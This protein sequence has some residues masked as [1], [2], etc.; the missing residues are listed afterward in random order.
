MDN[1]NE[2]INQMVNENPPEPGKKFNW[3]TFFLGV[4]A[5]AFLSTV[6][7]SVSFAL[8]KHESAPYTVTTTKVDN[9]DSKSAK[10]DDT[11][12]QD[13]DSKTDEYESVVNDETM[14]KLQ[15]LEQTID[16]YYIDSENVSTKTL[17]DGMYEGM[18]DSL[19]DVY[20]V[21]Y[22]EEELTALMEDTNG[23]Y[24]GIGAY[25]STDDTT[26]LPVIAGVM[27]G[28]PAQEAGLK[29]GD[30]CYK[31]DGKL[32]ESMTLEEFIRNVKGE[33]HTKVLLTIVREGESD[34]LEIEVERRQIQTPTVKYEMKEGNIGYI[35]IT[36]FDTVTSDQFTEALVTL[37]GQGMKGLVIDLRSNPGGNL[38]T[39]CEIASQLLPKGTIVYTVDKDGNRVDYN[40]DGKN[41]FDMPMVVLV[42]GYSASASEIL[43]GA[44]K[45]YEMGTLVGTTTYGK[46][47]V[48][49]I[50]PFSDGTAV[51]LTVSKYYTPNGINIHGTGIDPDVEIEYDP[52]AAEN[53][54]DN[55]LDK[56]LEI[57]A[58]EIG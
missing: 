8:V 50:I 13:E 52:E 55:Q 22:T 35:Q 30:V 12:E 38:D 41:E 57:I 51:K 3:G 16:E 58:E 26:G 6:V 1:E 10:E 28:S 53:G 44:I 27:D 21:Y 56:A 14:A 48:Q 2:M 46:G 5:G 45:D 39:V 36:E 4:V 54:V 40:C 49:R 37:K 42:N 15:L 7:F 17:T 18:L 24:Y 31:V 47:I 29:E 43:A 9:N 34:Y 19:G 32:T 20:S 23:I 25:I 33:E 11:E